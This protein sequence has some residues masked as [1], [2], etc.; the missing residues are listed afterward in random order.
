MYLKTAARL[1]CGFL[2]ISLLIGTSDILCYAESNDQNFS[3]TPSVS[4]F[5][6]NSGRIRDKLG[7]G[8]NY[9]I[10][11]KLNVTENISIMGSISYFEKDET[12][13]D[14]TINEFPIGNDPSGNTF[15]QADADDLTK[16]EKIDEL[17]YTLIPVMMTVLVDV[18]SPHKK[19]N[20]NFGGGAGVVIAKLDLKSTD[21]YNFVINDPANQANI[22]SQGTDENTFSNSISDSP[23]GVQLMTNLN[24]NFT[25][26]VGLTGNAKYMT[27]QSDSDKFDTDLGGFSVGGGFKI[28][29]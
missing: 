29:F 25:K 4:F 18:P 2:L 24:W 15:F 21:R 20:M 22:L 14:G 11:A 1:L 16:I 8:I 6:P 3:L 13:T 19:F 23:I 28:L 26:T 9:D 7:S 10:L 12:K 5:K 27:A 17:D